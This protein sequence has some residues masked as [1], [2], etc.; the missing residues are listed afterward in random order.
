M[1][2]RS[3][4]VETPGWVAGRE[5]R[6]G[7]LV[8]HG[9]DAGKDRAC[10]G[11]VA[12]HRRCA[13]GLLIPDDDDAA[14]VIRGLCRKGNPQ[15]SQIARKNNPQISQIA[16][17]RLQPRRSQRPQRSRRNNGLNHEDHEGHK[18]HKERTI[19]S[20]RGKMIPHAHGDVRAVIIGRRRWRLLHT[21]KPP[22][23]EVSTQTVIRSLPCF[24]ERCREAEISCPSWVSAACVCPWPIT[25]SISR[26][27]SARFAPR[28]TRASI[29]WTRPGPTMPARARSSWAWPCGMATGTRSSS[30]RSCP[31][32]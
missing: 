19:L 13:D 15:I 2:F 10:A 14:K 9:D 17:K 18:D 5:V 16:Q 1:H 7:V 11:P 32:G 23:I 22:A 8:N 27:P 6:V 12:H 20:L 28:S 26:G 31:R 4:L 24:T 3:N 21:A 25:R 30:P 29:T